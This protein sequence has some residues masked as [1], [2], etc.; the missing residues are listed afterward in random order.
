M[1]QAKE[2]KTLPEKKASF[3]FDILDTQDHIGVIFS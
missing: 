1:T 2:K 3:I